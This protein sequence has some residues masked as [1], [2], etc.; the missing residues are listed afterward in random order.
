[1]VPAR[2]QYAVVCSNEEKGAVA[3][4]NCKVVCIACRVREGMPTA[5]YFYSKY[6]CNH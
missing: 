5:S 6:A 3:R 1:M 2:S 4:K